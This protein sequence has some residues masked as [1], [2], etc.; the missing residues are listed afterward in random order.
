M[1]GMIVVG[2]GSWALGMTSAVNLIV[3]DIAH[4]IPLEF[5]AEEPLEALPEKLND[6]LDTLLRETDGVLIFADLIGGTPYKTAFTIASERTNV[7]VLG[8]TNLG[9]V[10]EAH[11]ARTAVGDLPGL[12][13][14]LEEKGKSHV[15]YVAGVEPLAD[16]PEDFSDGI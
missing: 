2:H 14:D 10:I 9:M 3:G 7:A 13:R 16:E 12:A 1:Y 4:Y 5:L 8:G 15:A 11:F 6:A